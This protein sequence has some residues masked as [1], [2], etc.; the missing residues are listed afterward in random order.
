MTFSELYYSFSTNAG[1]TWSPSE[2]LSIPFN[3]FLG[4]PDQ[5]KLGDYY[6]MVSNWS[7][8]NL[9]YSATFNGE[10]DVYFL[11]INPGIDFKNG[12]EGDDAGAGQ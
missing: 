1:V 3:H 12:F 4:Y 6:H 10:Q 9:A 2:P 8:A 7:G 5:S 11:R